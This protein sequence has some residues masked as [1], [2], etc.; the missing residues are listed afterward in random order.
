MKIG[1]LPLYIK[2]YDDSAPGMRPRLEAFY[3]TLASI[4]EAKGVEVIRTPFCRL[5]GEFREAVS[6]YERDGAD[7]IVTIH[8]AYSPS[9]ESIGALT[10]TKLPI[11]VLD[12]TET[13]E[14]GNM[15]DSKEVTYCHGIHGVMDMCSMLSR[16]EKPYAIAAGHYEKSDCIDRAIGFV[17]AACAAKALS[18]VKTAIMGEAFYGMGDFS[19]P[20]GEM[21][22]R[23][24]VEI[25]R[26]TA[27]EMKAYSDAVTDA[28]IDEKYALDIENYGKCDG[29]DEAEYRESV[30]ATLALNKMLSDKGA[31][32]FTV[33]FDAVTGLNTMPFIGA[34]EAMQRGVGYAGEGDT[35]TASFVGALLR[36]FDE[37][38]FVE[39]F[40]P[41]WKNSTL[42][43]SHMGET[44]YR[45]ADTRPLLKRHAVKYSSIVN[46]YSAP[47][48][49]KGGKGV[50]VNISRQKDDFRLLA[51]ECEMLSF[52]EDNFPKSMRGWMKTSTPTAEFLTDLSRAGATHHSIF[53]Y[54]ATEDEMVFFADLL[55]MESVII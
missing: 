3:E 31:S 4:F 6:T 36:A 48:R 52:D 37:T 10:E 9:L 34:C 53:V 33:N 7:A 54:G 20:D 35:L 42:F 26:P 11:V 2:L 17:K 28:E 41:D 12:T 18:S 46:P 38:N 21:K 14:F 30:R 19:I 22:S 51:S 40:C 5:D 43:M 15:Q 8:M 13:L 27:E 55:G 23:F 49:M 32:A 25:L 16:Y 1:F 24:G 39:I 50:F 44:N 47:T 29:F 45:L